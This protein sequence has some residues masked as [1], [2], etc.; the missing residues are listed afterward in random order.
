LGIASHDGSGEADRGPPII[1]ISLV[2]GAALAYEVLLTRLFSIIQW[3]HF[4]YMAISIALLGYGASGSLLA[5][6]Q[7]RLRLYFTGIFS[8]SAALFGVSSVASFSLAQ[9]LPFNALAVIWEPKQLIFLTAYYLLFATPFFCAAICVGLAFAVFPIHIGRVY[10]ADLLGGGLGALGIVAALFALF[11]SDALRVVGGLGFLA[12]ALASWQRTGSKWRS[13]IFLVGAAFLYAAVPTAWTALRFSEFKEVAQTL[14]IPGTEVVGEKSSPLGLLTVIRSPQ[15]PLRYAPGISLSNA[16]E[17]PPQLGLFTDGSGLSAI[18]TFHD[19]LA[20]LAYLDYT[21][22]ALPFHLLERAEVLIIGAGGGT[23]VLLALY[24]RA[25]RIDAVELNSQVVNLVGKTFADFAGHLYDRRN[26]H[27]HIAEGRGFVATAPQRYDI[28]QLPLLDSFA[29]AAAGTLSLSESYTYTVEAF[30]EYLRRLRPGGIIAITRWLKLPPRDS[31]KLFAT[32]ITALK[33]IGINEAERRL[34][35]IRS[36]NTTTL[37]VKNGPFSSTEIARIRAFADE[38]SFDLDYYPGMQRAQANRY[39][40]LEQPYLFDGATALLGPD[41]QSFVA[42]YKFDISPTTDDRPYFFDFFK[43]QAL[44][45][46]LERRTLGGAALLDWG[47]LILLSTLVQA[48]VLSF[49]FILAPLRFGQ[50]N[51]ATSADKWRVASY[52]LMIGLA[53]LFIEIASFQRF[54]LFLSHPVYSTA[55]VLCGFLVFAGVGSGISPQLTAWAKAK[56]A[57]GLSQARPA[58]LRMHLGALDVSIFGI[59]V[60]SLLYLFILPPLFRLLVAL[61]DVPKIA[62]SLLLIAPLAFCM[63]MPFPLALSRVSASA[64]GLVP[65]AWSINGCASVLSAILATLLAMNVGFT[66]VTLIASASYLLA[67]AI[68]RAPLAREQSDPFIPSSQ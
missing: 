42:Q 1:A 36:W 54:I 41:S 67:A 38:R 14:L 63:G 18:T 32:A 65:W 9:R 23:D 16:S 34:A 43:W 49:V 55:V 64:P 48:V 20:P 47:Y 3:H 13:T 50:T 59:V 7:H 10:C 39:N 33:R 45:E 58:W 62:V 68:F 6:V 57:E 52:F 29:A 25:A 28:I 19:D 30:E 27:V 22:A 51:S 21:S 35:L 40:I 37:L 61:P 17:P 26:V 5:L 44:P 31:L 56:R 2:S 66:W 12:A 8:F 15:I 53:F 11:P 4:A 60:V 24:H 46:L